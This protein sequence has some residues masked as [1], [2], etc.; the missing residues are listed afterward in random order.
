M[1]PSPTAGGVSAHFNCRQVVSECPRG[2]NA[3]MI[4]LAGR[5]RERL[6]SDLRAH[7]ETFSLTD[8]RYA[9]E[10]LKISLNTYKKCLQSGSRAPLTLKRQTLI[11]LLASA[12]L[13]PRRYGLSIHAPSQASPFGGYRKD[14]YD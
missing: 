8:A 4:R 2:R 14:D 13:D 11:A 9:G 6:Q 7:R 10:I 12:D 3:A 1:L 5:H